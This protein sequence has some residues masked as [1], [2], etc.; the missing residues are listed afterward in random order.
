[1]RFFAFFLL[2]IAFQSPIE[3][4]N[5]TDFK[6]EV[7]HSNEIIEWNSDWEYIWKQLTNQSEDQVPSEDEQIWYDVT[8]D[9]DK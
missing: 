8:V 4:F 5:A 6:Y 7:G 2:K 9:V 3:I 1:M